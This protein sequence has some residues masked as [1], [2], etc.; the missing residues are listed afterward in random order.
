MTIQ[1]QIDE[2]EWEIRAVKERVKVNQRRLKVSEDVLEMRNSEL[3]ELQKEQSDSEVCHIFVTKDKY[4]AAYIRAHLKILKWQQLN[5]PGY[6]P[7]WDN[8]HEKK[9]HACYI[10]LT[11]ELDWGVDFFHQSAPYYF[12]LPKITKKFINEMGD[13]YLRDILGVE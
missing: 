3:A 9:Y 5:D 4:K 10:H 13:L 11:K 1:K 6:K 12:S 8:E 7:N 2:K